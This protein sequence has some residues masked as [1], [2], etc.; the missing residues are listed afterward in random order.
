MSRSEKPRTGPVLIELEDTQTISPADAPPVPEV[1]AVDATGAAMQGAISFAG[2]KR[3]RLAGWFWSLLLTIT[4]FVLSVAA[5]DFV[6]SLIARQPVLG[7]AALSLVGAFILVL[8]IIALKEWVA[9]VRLRRVDMLHHAAEAAMVHNNLAEARGVV[10]KLKH[11]YRG[12]DDLRWG[13]ERL[14]ERE[15]DAFDVDTLL[16]LTERELL[17]PLD[18]AAVKEVESAARQVAMVTAIVPIA[19]A[20]VI[21]ALTANIRMIRRIA[22]IYGGRSG[23]LGGW[24]LTRAVM[25]HLVATGAVAVGDDMIG[26]LAGGGMLSKLSRR[27]GEG[28]VNGAL[29]A[30]VG[31]AALE[32]CRPLPFGPK[33]RPSVSGIVKRALTGLF[34]K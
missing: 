24:R 17:T 7:Y 6:S 31:V 2:R 25:A 26:S 29:T 30:R 5:Y 19:L 3:S 11:L 20:D 8:L 4:G 23:V 15:A 12:R 13:L 28:V 34:G 1:P 21:T 27:F 14:A 10:E 9:F 16:D 18:A 22:E 32:V 33:K